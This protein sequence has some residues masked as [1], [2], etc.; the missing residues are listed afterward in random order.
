MKTELTTMKKSFLLL[1]LICY[2]I[3][4]FSQNLDWVKTINSGGY[5]V[6]NDVCVDDNN[7]QYSIS[8]SGSSN[9]SYYN[10]ISFSFRY[11]YY[12]AIFFLISFVDLAIAF[13]ISFHWQF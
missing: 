5:A 1:L 9:S 2:N 8:Y 11:L 7:R 13:L 4:L 10:N 12:V 6:T 3:K